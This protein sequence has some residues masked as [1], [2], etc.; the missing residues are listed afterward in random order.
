MKRTRITGKKG[1]EIIEN[2]KK[3]RKERKLSQT[4]LAEELHTTQQNIQ[5][6][7]NDTTMPSIDILKQM[8]DFFETSVDYIIGY[9]DAS[10]MLIE[11]HGIQLTADEWELIDVYRSISDSQKSVVKTVAKSYIETKK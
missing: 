1:R 10:D 4:K 3:L 5:K 9:T 8:A 7:E 6:Y 11:H 2:L